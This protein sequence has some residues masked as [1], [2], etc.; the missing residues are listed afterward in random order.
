MVSTEQEL[1]N[2]TD[3]GLFE[4]IGSAFLREQFPHL[5]ALIDTGRNEKGETIKGKL[6]GTIEYAK[7][8][9]ALI[10]YT[11]NDSNLDYKWFSEN[12]SKLGDVPKTIRES[13]EIT[14]TRP[15]ATFEV[16]LV[17]HQ[18]LSEDLV[19]KVV[20]YPRP[21]NVEIVVI[22]NS[23]ISHFLDMTGRGQYLRNKYLGIRQ[24]LISKELLHNIAANNLETYR[25]ESS[26]EVELLATLE[27]REN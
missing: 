24:D 10:Q 14:V 17:T 26:I 7:D 4:A 6:D 21:N 27:D 5:R 16:Y 11:I 19:K 9:F 12:E 20:S 1:S 13:Q 8:K 2:L 23:P 25:A 22:E 18:K 3:A 15:A